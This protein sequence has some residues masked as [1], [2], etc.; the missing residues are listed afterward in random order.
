M[1]SATWAALALLGG[2]AWCRVFQGFKPGLYQLEC[3]GR[4][5]YSSLFVVL[6]LGE[7]D[8]LFLL[9]CLK[10]RAPDPRPNQSKVMNACYQ[11]FSYYQH[12]PFC[13]KPAT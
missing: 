6:V 7:R 12:L 9:P 8:A 1:S 5:I 13:F 2:Y 3:L 4:S 10:Q 11:Q